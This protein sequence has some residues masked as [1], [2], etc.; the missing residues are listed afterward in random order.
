M[1]G[2]TQSSSNDR[3]LD[4]FNKWNAEGSGGNKKGKLLASFNFDDTQCHQTNSGAISTQRQKQ[5][6]HKADQLMGA[7]L[8]C[9]NDLK[10]PQDAPAGKPY[11]LYWVWVCLFPSLSASKISNHR[12]F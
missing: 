9:Q 8:W 5:F 11:T 4:I 10:L 2:T 3:F 6:P 7:D 1:Y 12:T